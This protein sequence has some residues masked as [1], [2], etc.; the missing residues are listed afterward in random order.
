MCTVT[1][2]TFTGTNLKLLVH[3]CADRIVERKD[4]VDEAEEEAHKGGTAEAAPI[5]G[6]RPAI[7]RPHVGNQPLGP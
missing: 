2:I 4:V 7:Q 3:Y 5:Y 1:L 6:K